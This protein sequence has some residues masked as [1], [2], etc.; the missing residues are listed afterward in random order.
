M[1]RSLSSCSSPNI[2]TCVRAFRHGVLFR[3]K[4]D[5]Q[6]CYAKQ[7]AYVFKCAARRGAAHTPRLLGI[8]GVPPGSRAPCM[9]SLS[10]R[11]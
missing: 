3:I 6:G 10:A 9:L 5:V 1:G 7:C 2:H 8:G 11:N 4:F